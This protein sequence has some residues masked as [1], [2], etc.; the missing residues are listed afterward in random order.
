MLANVLRVFWEI[1]HTRKW[2]WKRTQHDERLLWSLPVPALGMNS[3]ILEVDKTNTC[4]DRE[5]L[6]RIFCCTENSFIVRGRFKRRERVVRTRTWIGR[7]LGNLL[8]LLPPAD[9]VWGKVMFLLYPGGGSL[10][11]GV[12]V[13]ETLP[14]R[15]TPVQWRVGGTHPTGMLSCFRIFY[16]SMK[17]LHVQV[18]GVKFLFFPIFSYFSQHTP[19]FPIF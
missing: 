5:R 1:L 8:Q 18:Q 12:S 6:T 11:R 7:K 2:K 19:V 14:P 3:A 9:E 10:S 15:Q 13:R 16:I 4:Y 17:L